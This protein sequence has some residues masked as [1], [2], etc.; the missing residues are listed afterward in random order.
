M[1]NGLARYTLRGRLFC[2][3][4]SFAGHGVD[5][6]QSSAQASDALKCSG[7]IARMKVIRSAKWEEGGQGADASTQSGKHAGAEPNLN[8]LLPVLCKSSSFRRDA[9]LNVPVISRRFHIKFGLRSPILI[10]PGSEQRLSLL[11][12]GGTRSRV[13]VQQHAMCEAGGVRNDACAG[14]TEQLVVGM[15]TM[16]DALVKR[17]VCRLSPILVSTSTSCPL[18]SSYQRSHRLLLSFIMSWNLL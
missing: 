2:L 15:L 17:R 16:A 5:V 6:C 8:Q 18:T 10:I 13:R 9:Q 12:H 7:S 4:S 1:R 11:I 3:A 14:Q